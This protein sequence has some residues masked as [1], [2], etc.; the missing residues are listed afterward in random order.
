MHSGG[1]ELALVFLLAAVVGVPVFKRF[2]LGAVL[3]YLA[4]GVVLGPF[5]LRVVRDADPVLAASEIGVVMLLFVIGLELS[6]ARLRVM[7]RPVFGVGGLQVLLSG[8]ALG[9][10]A[11]AT[12]LAWRSALVVGFGLALSSTA[13]GLQLLAERKALTSDHGRLAFAILLFQD[14]AAIPLL[15]AVPLLG[16]ATAQP[17]WWLA[18]KALLAIAALVFGGRLLLR[19]VFRIVARTR[20]PEVFTAT[21]LLVVLGSAWLM[22]LA[23]LSMGLGAFLAGALLADSEFRHEL[24]AQIQPFEGLLLGLF[25]MAVGM[26]IDLQRVAAEPLVIAGGSLLLMAVKFAL[27]FALGL[28]PGGLDVRGALLLGSVLAL[29]GE[30]AF[31]VFGEADRVGLFDG[32]LRDRLVAMVGV[33]MALTP[34]LLI[35]VAKLVPAHARRTQ[36]P[37]DRIPDDHP[38]VLIAGLG[39]FGQIVARLLTAQ[40]I[41]YVAIEHSPEQVDFMRRFG[42]QLYYGDPSRPELLR[43]AGAAHVKVFVVA[44]DDP[45][46]NLKAVRLIRHDYPDAMVFARA[47]NRRHAWELMDLGA[48]AVRETFHSSLKM[49]ERVLVAL[50]ETAGVAARRADRFREHDEALL[51]SQHQVYDDEAALIQTSQEARKDL[52]QLFAADRGEGVLGGM[53]AQDEEDAAS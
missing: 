38:L 18:L 28:R 7:R 31:V 11:L 25:F 26:S 27:L 22:Q 1:L 41:R 2:G 9:I 51:V 48:Q 49:G 24:E 6:P 4:A 33:S 8:I 52:E 45:E 32:M 20:M 30:F 21:A 3:G 47:R 15:A 14:L 12:G 5:G 19:Q 40:R 46:S 39:R 35:V 37:F 16:G 13:I 43:A 53:V 34:L 10:I 17:L 42:S 29:G 50:G 23:G 44:I 36:R